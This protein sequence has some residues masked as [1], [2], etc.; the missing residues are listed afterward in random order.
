M[1]KT[2]NLGKVG[3]TLGGD[4]DSS[5]NYASRTCV[6]YNHVS[7]TSKKDVPA[8]IAPGTNDEYWQKVS[9]RGAQGIQ[10]ER[11]PQGNSAFDGTGIELVN[12]LTQGGEASAL[13]AEQGKILKTELTELELNTNGFY[14]LGSIT[15][16]D[17]S[18][19]AF[20]RKIDLFN[21]ADLENSH[22]Y[23]MRVAGINGSN[24]QF[25]INDITIGAN[26]DFKQ[27]FDAQPTGIK[28]YEFTNYTNYA[29]GN[30]SVFFL[31][32][33]VD[34]SNYSTI[35]AHESNLGIYNE[36]YNDFVTKMQSIGFAGEFY[37]NGSYELSECV[38]Q[39]RLWGAKQSG[40]KY[41][42]RLLGLLDDRVQVTIYDGSK[43][44]DITW[45][46]NDKPTGLHRYTKIVSGLLLDIVIDWD[47][48]EGGTS[49]VVGST[50][51][52][53]HLL[54]PISSEYE[55]SIFNIMFDGAFNQGQEIIGHFGTYGSFM[56]KSSCVVAPIKKVS[57]DSRLDKI[58]LVMESEGEGYILVGEIDQLNL[59][60][61]RK[62]YKVSLIA[63]TNII[64]TSAMDIYVK[65]G[66]NVAFRYM[67]N[68]IRIYADIVGDPTSDGAFMYTKDG[69]ETSN[70]YQLQVYGAAKEF[71]CMFDA[72]FVTSEIIKGDIQGK[73]A[74]DKIADLT[75]TIAN[76]ENNQGFITDANGNK[77]RLVVVNGDVKAQSLDF[78]HMIVVGN[79]YTTHPTTTDTESDYTN[80]FWWGHWSM[81]AS[82]KNVAWTTLLEKNLQQRRP[83]AKVT[84]VFG[85]RYETK[86][87]SLGADDAFTY[88]DNGWKGLKPNLANFADVDCVTIFLG[89]N[90]GSDGWYDLYKP[91]VEQFISWF[92]SAT[93]VL[94]SS[95]T[96][97]NVNA[98]ISKVA[99][100]KGLQYINMYGI[101]NTTTNSKLGNFVFADD[102]SMHQIN[103]GAVATHFGDYGEWVIVDRVSKALGYDNLS[104]YFTIKM[105]NA[106]LLVDVAYKLPGGIVSIFADGVSSISVTTE[107]GQAVEVTSHGDTEYGRIF[108]FIMP[109]E[110][111]NVA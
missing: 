26:L 32:I 84:P 36:P 71:K 63:G 31:R 73:L 72:T 79:S 77:Y 86:L 34:W 85:R 95:V 76:I 5:K 83:S 75:T 43:Y 101:K 64:D 33:T 82:S 38:K 42:F 13:S 93:I 89:D 49:G 66:E 12:N 45:A 59:F 1:A 88:W 21:P 92:P 69:Y 110:N 19:L 65:A 106:Q 7:W 35:L 14:A 102:G 8:G 2:I 99:T 39:I 61:A 44:I 60:V 11:G 103:Y 94:M 68:A 70:L 78:S 80:T 10:G 87:R 29:A 96:K 105:A 109:E 46:I 67:D 52:A 9:E 17:R 98:D 104:S 50:Y 15:S 28:T 81:A 100:E 107:S 55:E 48:F 108:T 18:M 16:Q 22:T 40:Q 51:L 74:E 4:Y 27:G 91:M 37:H 56:P 97:T 23:R 47:K 20:I 53:G 58:S 62:E 24:V 25:T 90:Y 6:F 3:V 54:I 111:V 57:Y 30:G 41:S